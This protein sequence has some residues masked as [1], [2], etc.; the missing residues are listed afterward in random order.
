MGEGVGRKSAVVSVQELL[1]WRRS[2]LEQLEALYSERDSSA[3][4]QPI[5]VSAEIA[6][7][8]VEAWQKSEVGRDLNRKTNR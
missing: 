3:I 4:L 2:C 8:N 1:V 5:K 7:T 6:L